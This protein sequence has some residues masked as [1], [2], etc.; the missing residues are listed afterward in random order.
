MIDHRSY[1]HNLKPEKKFMPE[2][3]SNPL[4]LNFTTAQVV[5]VAAMINHKFKSFSAVQLY[6]LSYIHLH[7]STSTGILRTHKMTSSQMA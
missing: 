2:R 6:E 4:I 3:D 1:T 7:P 5:S